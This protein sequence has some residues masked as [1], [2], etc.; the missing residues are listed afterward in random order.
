MLSEQRLIDINHN[1]N[2][3]YPLAISSLMTVEFA[4]V[5]MADDDDDGVSVSTTVGASDDVSAGAEGGLFVDSEATGIGSRSD[6]I[7]SDAS[8]WTA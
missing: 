7:V 3:R 4:G 2:N 8:S 5:A 6:V 1:N